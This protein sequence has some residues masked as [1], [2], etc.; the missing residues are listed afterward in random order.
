MNTSYG[1]VSGWSRFRR[2]C[3]LPTLYQS[4]HQ[5]HY[6]V[7][8]GANPVFQNCMCQVQHVQILGW[9]FQGKNTKTKQKRKHSVIFLPLFCREEEKNSLRSCYSFASV[10]SEYVCVAN[11]SGFLLCSLCLWPFSCS[12]AKGNT[13]AKGEFS[14]VRTA[15]P[16]M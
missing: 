5:P 6:T 7:A 11:R 10:S 9:F 16:Q 4:L 3:F 14:A 12:L 1:A 13:K 8:K 15:S 2:Q